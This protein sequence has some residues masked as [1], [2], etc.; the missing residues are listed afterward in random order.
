VRLRLGLL[1]VELTLECLSLEVVM[2]AAFALA[3][4]SS[5]HPGIIPQM[6]QES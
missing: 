2:H 1:A 3:L 5:V 4:L 6:G